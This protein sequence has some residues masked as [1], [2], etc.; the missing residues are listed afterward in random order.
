[1]NPLTLSRPTDR[2]TGWGQPH[3]CVIDASDL[4]LIL[5]TP[6][7]VGVAPTIHVARDMGGRV[8]WRGPFVSM[9]AAQAEADAWLADLNR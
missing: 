3:A 6:T 4:P 1:M 7:L 5:A 9:A 8:V 2:F